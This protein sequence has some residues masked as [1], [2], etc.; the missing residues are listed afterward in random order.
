MKRRMRMPMP[1]LSAQ[2][3]VAAIEMALILTVSMALFP[4][5]LWFGRIF[6]EYN[7]MLKATDEA[8][9]YL[10][11]LSQMEVTTAATWLQA[12]ATAT[13][14]IS[15]AAAGAGLSAVPDL[16]QI[17]CHPGACGTPNV[18]PTSFELTY[19]LSMIDDLFYDTSNGAFTMNVDLTVPYVGR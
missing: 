7:V 8:S 2:R 1:H 6:Y 5:V 15:T 19:S 3:G 9:R 12:S 18:P 14:M 13:K 16:I 4:F 10:A 17:G 11:S